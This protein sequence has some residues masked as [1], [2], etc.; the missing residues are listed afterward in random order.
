[1]E[2]RT[3]TRALESIER[4][5]E[6]LLPAAEIIGEEAHRSLR[7]AKVSVRDALIGARNMVRL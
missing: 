2:F 7:K 3:Y 1:M 5:I 6:D 4:R